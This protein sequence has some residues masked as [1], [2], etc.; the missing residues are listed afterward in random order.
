MRTRVNNGNYLDAVALT[1]GG[2]APS[3]IVVG[4]DG[5]FITGC[6]TESVDVASYRSG[7]HDTRAIVVAKGNRS[8]G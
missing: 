1:V 3:I 4:K 5:N 8:F 2:C 6:N 7:Q